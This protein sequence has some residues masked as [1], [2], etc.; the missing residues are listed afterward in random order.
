[1]ILGLTLLSMTLGTLLFFSIQKNLKLIDKLDEINAQVE[2]S[3]DILDEYHQRID[4]KSKTE[5]LFDDPLVKDLILDIK[6][7][8]NAVLLIA[9]KVYS[10]LE[11]FDEDDEDEGTEP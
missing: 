10:P 8:K 9:N 4:L 11:E 7:C 2:E 1:M 6:G 5:I 3:L